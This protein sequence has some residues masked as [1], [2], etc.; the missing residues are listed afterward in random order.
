LTI[1]NWIVRKYRYAYLY[2][3]LYNRSYG[4]FKLISIRYFRRKWLLKND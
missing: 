3:P 1:I 4:F 2:L